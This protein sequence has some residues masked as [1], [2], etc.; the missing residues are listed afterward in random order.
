[1]TLVRLARS[2]LLLALAFA[3]LVTGVSVPDRLSPALEPAA[4]TSLFRPGNIISNA[5]FYDGRSMSAAQIQSFLNSKGASCRPASGGPACLKDYVM[6]TPT[7]RRTP[8]ARARTPV[9]PASPRRRS[10][11]RWGWPAGSIRAC[12]W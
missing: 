5:V 7:A 1:M 2:G 4:D 9:R 11:P 10:S 8:T 3:C 12:S 6:A